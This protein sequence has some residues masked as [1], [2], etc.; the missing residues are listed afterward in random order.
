[1][2]WLKILNISYLPSTNKFS[3]GKWHLDVFIVLTFDAIC[4]GMVLEYLSR[5]H[6]GHPEIYQKSNNSATNLSHDELK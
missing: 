1:M 3:L 4:Q 6:Q 5:N 2:T